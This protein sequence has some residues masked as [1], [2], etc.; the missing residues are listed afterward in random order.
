MAN[1]IPS[2]VVQSTKDGV[3]PLP[4]QLKTNS[5]SHLLPMQWILTEHDIQLSSTVSLIAQSILS[6]VFVVA[7][8]RAR[9]TLLKRSASG[10]LQRG[11]L[12]H[13]AALVAMAFLALANV[14][15]SILD[16]RSIAGY[17]GKLDT[18]Y[19]T[20]DD[21]YF[22]FMSVRG[23]QFYLFMAQTMVANMLMIYT[24]YAKSE[25]DDYPRAG[26]HAIG[27]AILGN[28]FGFCAFANSLWAFEFLFLSAGINVL[29][30]VPLMWASLRNS[31]TAWGPRAAVRFLCSRKFFDAMIQSAALY[32]VA[33]LSLLVTFHL[34]PNVL[35]YPNISILSPLMGIAF[36]LAAMSKY[37]SSS[38]SESDGAIH[39]QEDLLVAA[40][41]ALV[42]KE[43][44]AEA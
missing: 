31:D 1:F 38:Y 42:E 40:E 12:V 24:F 10:S 37:R 33:S 14:I 2:E 32:R 36:S 19:K 18:A 44:A 23:V 28:I 13:L 27:Y 43:E 26:S 11:S 20:F 3:L 4:F 16:S 17:Q 34:D 25:C 22:L 9:S 39:L 7:Y 41:E 15:M 21:Q 8:Q 5:S 29:T 6:V 35:F 30:S